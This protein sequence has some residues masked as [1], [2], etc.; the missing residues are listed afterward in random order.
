MSLFGKVRYTHYVWRVGASRY[1][2]LSV[3]PDRSTPRIL[4]HGLCR[5][6]HLGLRLVRR[7]TCR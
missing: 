6:D 3:W 2:G 4:S 7:H 1:D 5:F